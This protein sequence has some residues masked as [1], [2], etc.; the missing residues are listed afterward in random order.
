MDKK[1]PQK[2]FK[3]EDKNRQ[4][5][6]VRSTVL[7]ERTIT[8]KT[9]FQCDS[10]AAALYYSGEFTREMWN[11]MIESGLCI[12]NIL[13]PKVQLEQNNTAKIEKS[14]TDV[15]EDRRK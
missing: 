4:N 5:S 15:I 12:P 8:D 11:E 7:P 9:G 10:D 6:V 14:L 13:D 2:H 3:G 1:T